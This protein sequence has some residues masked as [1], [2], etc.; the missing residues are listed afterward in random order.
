MSGY[1]QYDFTYTD[2][3][4]VDSSVVDA[5]YFN[6]ADNSVVLDLNDEMYRYTGVSRNDVENLVNAASVG[7]YYNVYFK[8]DHGPAEHLGHYDDLRWT[9]VSNIEVQDATKEYSLASPA[10]ANAYDGISSITNT[11]APTKEYSLKSPEVSVPETDEFVDVTSTVFFVLGDSDKV[12]E[13]ASNKDNL[14]DAIGEVNDFV[15]RV[16]QKGRVV[17]VVFEF[18]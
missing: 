7:A 16:S 10:V 1:D 17:K 14:D 4:D 15:T 13:F 12:Y 2:G 5:V 18:E 11:S 9:K 6:S 8:R 3:Y